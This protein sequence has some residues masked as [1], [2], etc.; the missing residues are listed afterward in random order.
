MPLNWEQIVVDARDPRTLGHWWAAAL[1]WVVTNDSR[2]EFEIRPSADSTPGIIFAPV[3]KN[4]TV[5]N[6][7]HPDFRPTTNRP[8][9][10]GCY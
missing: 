1:G 6:R 3:E 9:S 4:K 2:D 5:K 7:V 8:R 10:N